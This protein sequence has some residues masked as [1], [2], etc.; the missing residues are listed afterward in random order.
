MLKHHG[1]KNIFMGGADLNF[2]GKG[3][4]L[5][6]HGYDIAY[7]KQ[8]WENLGKEILISGVFM[9]IDFFAGEKILLDLDKLAQPFNLT[10]LTLNLHE[11]HGFTD[12]TCESKNL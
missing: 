7:G 8:H 9:M 4:F 11:P 6:Q 3:Q 12:T 1:Y 2:A 10:M 5:A